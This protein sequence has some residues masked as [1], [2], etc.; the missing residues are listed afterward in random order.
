[1]PRSGAGAHPVR[2]PPFHAAFDAAA[3]PKSIVDCLKGHP[4]CTF[5]RLR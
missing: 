2:G 5:L 3:K 1:M 4:A